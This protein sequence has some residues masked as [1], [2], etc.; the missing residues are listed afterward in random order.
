MAEGR[1][2]NPALG[3]A[4]VPG[5]PIATTRRVSASSIARYKEPI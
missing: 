3:G 2:L 4:F 5:Y 1:K